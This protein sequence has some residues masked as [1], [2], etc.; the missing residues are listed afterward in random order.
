MEE[1]INTMSVFKT[2]S[3]DV[4][5]RALRRSA[6]SVTALLAAPATLARMVTGSYCTNWSGVFG[7]TEHGPST[8]CDQEVSGEVLSVEGVSDGTLFVDGVSTAVRAGVGVQGI[9]VLKGL[10]V[11]ESLVFTSDPKE[12]AEAPRREGQRET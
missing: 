4:E 7:S 6:L 5:L 9:K 1:H 3:L 11:S 10:E 12:Y 2:S 8:V